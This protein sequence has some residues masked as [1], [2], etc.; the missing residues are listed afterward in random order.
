[1][2]IEDFDFDKNRQSYPKTRHWIAIVVMTLIAILLGAVGI[3]G[4]LI[5]YPYE[6]LEINPVEVNENGFAVIKSD[7]DEVKDG[8]PVVRDD[9]LVEVTACNP[10]YSMIVERWFDT[11]SNQLPGGLL[12]E[13]E[14]QD[15]VVTSSLGQIQQ[16]YVNE[17][18]CD[19]TLVSSIPIGIPNNLTEGNVY[20]LRSV[21]EY[22]VNSLRSDKT[23]LITEPFI[24]L[25]D[26]EL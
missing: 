19:P 11:I 6:P 2:D 8:Y 5:L 23:V 26:S 9:V 3:I 16:F 17:R 25:G 20:R 1:M 14:S 4:A 24:Y 10:G 18:L 13:R 12:L 22:D 21:Y 7:S 15:A